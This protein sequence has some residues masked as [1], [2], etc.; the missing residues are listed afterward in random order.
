MVIL[1]N[2]G[3]NSRALLIR[4]LNDLILHP[5]Y[6]I[7]AICSER[8]KQEFHTF[9]NLCPNEIQY[10]KSVWISSLRSNEAIP[11]FPYDISKFIELII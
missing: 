3:K 10:G 7:I 9:E 5:R 1:R 6:W 8:N 4:K 11:K 2:H